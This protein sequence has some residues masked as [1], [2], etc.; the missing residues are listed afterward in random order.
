MITQTKKNKP[1]QVRDNA[2]ARVKIEI[3]QFFR[4]LFF[5]GY[6]WLTLRITADIY[7]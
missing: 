3:M 4:F 1:P 7:I 5:N 2:K 6:D